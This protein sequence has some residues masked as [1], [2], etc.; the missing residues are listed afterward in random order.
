MVFSSLEFLFIFLPVFM[1]FYMLS[2]Q[3]GKNYTLL[4]GSIIFYA[5][6]ALD[7]PSYLIVFVI[8]IVFNYLIAICIDKGNRSRRLWLIIGLICNFSILFV[9][10]YTNFFLAGIAKKFFPQLL[11]ADGRIV[12]LVLPIGISFYTFQA[13]S[14]LMDIYRREISAQYSIVNFGMYISMFPQLIAGPIVTYSKVE[15]YIE[16][17]TCNFASIASGSK[18]FIFGLG[19]KVLLANQLGSLWRALTDIGFDSISTRLAWMGIAA[20]SFQI[21]FDFFGYSVMAIGLG[22]MLGFRLPQNFDHPYT[23]LTMTDFWRKWH[24]TLG[25]W[26]REYLYIPL[27]GNRKGDLITYRNLFIVWSLT[28]LWHG[29]SLNYLIWGLVLFVMIAAEKM[30]LGEILRKFPLMGHLYMIF[31]IPI[32]WVFFSIEDFH[33]IGVFFQRLFPF[34]GVSANQLFEGDYL[35]YLNQYGLYLVLGLFFSTKIPYRIYSLIKDRIPGYI[36]LLAVFWLS[37]YAMY[38]GLDDPFLYFRF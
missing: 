4:I 6:S 28:G 9:Y 21:Y 10:K 12:D 35:K 16:R 29:A 31:F 18:I 30:F 11:L 27:G 32:T 13:V 22:V 15:D 17:R 7:R 37:V 2:P 14:Y 36:F 24:I 1:I 25:S 8:S 3:S 5:Y 23:A 19:L 38:R 33:S 20:R 26:F 34:I